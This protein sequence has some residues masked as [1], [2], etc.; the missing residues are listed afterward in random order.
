MEL[1]DKTFKDNRTGETVRVI[2]SFE[3]IAI[4][5][6]KEKIDTR[7][8]TNPLYYTEQ[9]DPKSFFD[10][11]YAYNSLA[12]K[13]K[14]IPSDH[15]TDVDGGSV[16][17]I[18]V[19]N[20]GIR[21]TTDESAVM[22]TSED[23]ERA[24]LAKKYGAVLDNTSTLQRQNEAFSKYLDDDELPVVSPIIQQPVNQQETNIQRVEVNRD[25]NQQRVVNEPPIVR[26]DDPIIS[27][28]KNVKRVTDFSVTLDIKNKIPR[29][30]FI[31]MM[32]DSYEMSII[33]FLSEEMT[34]NLLK[35]P[36]IIRN[37]ISEKI[38]EMVYK[39]DSKKKTEKPKVEKPIPPKT[40]VIKEGENPVPKK[41]KKVIPPPPPDRMLKEGTEPPKPKSQ[42]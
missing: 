37:M 13:I 22:M 14:S 12:D 29:L 26:I 38:K 31:E 4:L 19:D 32:E 2:D 35:N 8:L 30:D 28:F 23:D 9:I 18:Q 1:K 41:D 3:N 40:Q 6:N 33:D 15:I 21:P 27:M 10:N 16:V 5:E 42:E 20:N 11:Q 36:H 17:K 34:Q 25:N 39:K 7:R 24:E